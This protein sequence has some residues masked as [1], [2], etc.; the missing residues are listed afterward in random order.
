MEST[1]DSE[2]E[3]EG[4]LFEEEIEENGC[5]DNYSLRD[6]HYFVTIIYCIIS[7]YIWFRRVKHFD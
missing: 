6:T 7:I 3:S 1:S 4:S 5:K 2:T